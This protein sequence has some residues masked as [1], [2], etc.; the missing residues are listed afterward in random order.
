MWLF[1]SGSPCMGGRK[2]C[3]R[4]CTQSTLT[5]GRK[6]KETCRMPDDGEERGATD[7]F[8]SRT[9]LPGRRRFR[10]L[11]TAT[12]CDLLGW[13]AVPSLPS[14]RSVVPA[15]HLVAVLEGPDLD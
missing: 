1:P 11:P 10:K 2:Y 14:R 12:D 4:Y 7:S 8:P 3:F 15:S 9:M 5:L 13:K 6:C